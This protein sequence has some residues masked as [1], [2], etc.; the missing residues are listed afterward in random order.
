VSANAAI[1]QELDGQEAC[2]WLEAGKQGSGLA[3]QCL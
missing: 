3:P 2:R 1:M